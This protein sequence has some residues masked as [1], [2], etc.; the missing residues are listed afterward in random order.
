MSKRTLIKISERFKLSDI[1]KRNA[2]Y[3]HNIDRQILNPQFWISPKCLLSCFFHPRTDG[4]EPSAAL[5][6]AEG[7]RRT[8]FHN[9]VSAVGGGKKKKNGHGVENLGS[10][11]NCNHHQ[12]NGVT[13]WGKISQQRVASWRLFTVPHSRLYKKGK[14]NL[15]VWK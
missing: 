11:L 9:V 7:T 13:W 14:G 10:I 8:S 1:A 6:L 12:G 5:E 4:Q 3:R 15:C 2:Q